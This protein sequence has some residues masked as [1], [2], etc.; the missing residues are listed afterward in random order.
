MENDIDLKV[1]LADL[2]MRKGEKEKAEELYLEVLELDPGNGFAKQGLE[3][4]ITLKIP[5]WHFDMLADP[6][7]NEAFNRAIQRGVQKGDRVLDIGTG[8][9]LLAMMAIRSGAGSVVACEANPDI[10]K[11]AEKVIAT[12]GYQNSIKVIAKKSDQIGEE[13]CGGKFDIIVS[14][15]LASG[16]L[17][18]GVVPTLRHASKYLA[19]SGAKIIPAGISL[20][21]R[22]VEVPRLNKV[23][24]I[25]DISGFDLSDFDEF[26]VSD[27]SNLITIKQEEHTFLSD[28]FSLRSY[29]FYNIPD[30]EVPL[31]E[32]EVE[33]YTI[34]CVE[35]GQLQAVVFWFDLHMDEC[36]SYSS[37]P[38]G[39]LVHWQQAIYYF[40]DP[41][42]VKKGQ[43]VSLQALYSDCLVRFRLP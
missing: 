37:G 16:A 26:R 35:K 30:K 2:L 19:K 4:L 29:D 9:G 38:E 36:H 5:E 7:R 1:A 12:N 13:E 3:K 41:M 21:A 15:I 17:G 18:E 28:E 33:T 40:E 11:V 14:E 34:E 27:T 10:A 6:L 8:S 23:N 32:P 43:Q 22:L 39:G 42:E 31:E 25:K 20:K 24:P